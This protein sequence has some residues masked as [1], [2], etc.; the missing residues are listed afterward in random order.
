MEPKKRLNN[1]LGTAL[2]FASALFGMLFFAALTWP[3]LEANFYFGFN[4]GAE[5]KL[6]LICP[7]ILTPQDSGAI[8]AI[9]ANKVDKT[10]SP[11]F[12]ANFSGPMLRSLRTQPSIEPGKTEAIKWPVTTTDV[13]FGHLIM[14]QVYQFSSYHTPTATATCG[15]L[16]LYLPLLT[17]LQVYILALVLSLLGIAIGIV[18]WVTDNRPLTGRSLESFWGMT[19]LGG[20]VLLGIVFGSLGQW[21]LGTLTLALSLLMFFIQ[22]TRKLNPS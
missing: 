5:T 20:I 21:L 8:T 7:H 15:S 22:V 4:G 12:Q 19:L 14:A 2:F 16:Y 1:R 3:S 17:G 6:N 13:D 10:I 18:L 11:V 9:V